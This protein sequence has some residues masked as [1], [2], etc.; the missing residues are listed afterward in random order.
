MYL[1]LLVD[2]GVVGSVLWWTPCALIV[3]RA[4]ARLH[5]DDHGAGASLH[6]GLVLS[7]AAFFLYGLVE[8][9]NISNPYLNTSWLVLGLLAA[10]SHHQRRRRQ[11]ALA[12]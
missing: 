1:Q 9:L 6:L 11:G 7:A 10:S 3:R 12:A 8:T 5:L 2:L 4:I